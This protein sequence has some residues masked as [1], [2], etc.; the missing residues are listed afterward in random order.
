M[1]CH[2]K[3]H[4]LNNSTSVAFLL[5]SFLKHLKLL[6][7]TNSGYTCST[8]DFSHALN[9]CRSHLKYLFI[10]WSLVM[11]QI[12]SQWS[13]QLVAHLRL[14]FH[15]CMCPLLG[16]ISVV[17]CGW[18]CMHADCLYSVNLYTYMIVLCKVLCLNCPKFDHT[19]YVEM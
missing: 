17:W 5:F 4:G 14:V 7:G 3:S 16:K 11:E 13:T 2:Q 9:S 12:N 19:L 15:V 6:Y 10:S 18:T 1:L 8:S